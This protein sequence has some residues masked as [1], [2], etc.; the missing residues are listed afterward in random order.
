VVVATPD[1]SIRR[2]LSRSAGATVG[3]GLA[4]DGESVLDAEPGAT[5]TL[6]ATATSRTLHWQQPGITSIAGHLT[7]AGGAGAVYVARQPDGD[8]EARLL[9]SWNGDG[10]PRELLRARGGE[11]FQLVGW[12]ENRREVVI[13]RRRLDDDSTKREE[14]VW[15][16]PLDGSPPISTGISLV[17]LRD[18]SMHPDGRRIAFNAGWKQVEHWTMEHVLH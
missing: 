16:V 3:F 5:I 12:G 15:R 18:A 14:T 8:G 2:T 6:R 11:A 1:G 17:G 9:M 4:D 7:A 10:A 13:I